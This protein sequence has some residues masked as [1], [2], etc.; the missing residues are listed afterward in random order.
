MKPLHLY[1]K[2]NDVWV[3]KTKTNAYITDIDY[4]ELINQPTLYKIIN[5]IL[6]NEYYGYH[7]LLKYYSQK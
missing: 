7:T 1:Y 4:N 3:Q 2:P 6:K 5:K